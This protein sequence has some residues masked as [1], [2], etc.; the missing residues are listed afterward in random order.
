MGFRKASTFTLEEWEEMRRMYRAGVPLAKIGRE[1]QVNYK[2]ITRHAKKECWVRTPPEVVTE[3]NVIQDAVR[4]VVDRLTPVVGEHSLT[5]E[6]DIL[7]EIRTRP[8]LK[9]LLVPLKPGQSAQV[10]EQAIAV[11]SHKAF[12]DKLKHLFAVISSEPEA[13]RTTK[14]GL[15]R[16]LLDLSLTHEK[17]VNTDRKV[18]GI[19]ASDA[20]GTKGVIIVVAKLEPDEWQKDARQVLNKEAVEA[21]YETVEKGAADESQTLDRQRDGGTLQESPGRRGAP[22]KEGSGLAVLGEKPVRGTEPRSGEGGREEPPEPP[23]TR[24]STDGLPE[25]D[26]GRPAAGDDLGG[27]NGPGAGQLP[28]GGAGPGSDGSAPSG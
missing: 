5:P 10:R 21:E 1:M 16:A 27:V 9:D 2:T 6:I 4:T 3:R 26:E 17:I 18:L 28:Q 24:G 8:E 20:A 7:E 19:D 25:G 15:T 22:D 23:A 12:S 11:Q 14:S 13:L